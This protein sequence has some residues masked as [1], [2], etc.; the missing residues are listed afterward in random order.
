MA[1]LGTRFEHYAKRVEDLNMY[2]SHG[3]ESVHKGVIDDKV[4]A[5]WA[6]AAAAT[7]SAFPRLRRI[8]WAEWGHNPSAHRTILRDLCRCPTVV[9]LVVDMGWHPVNHFAAP[10]TGLD[11]RHIEDFKLVYTLPA[12]FTNITEIADTLNIVGSWLM[13]THSVKSLSLCAP[14][15]PVDLVCMPCAG[16]LRELDVACCPDF[17]PP[18]DLLPVSFPQ[19][20][21][22][23]L[24]GS[25]SPLFVRLAHILLA[26][27]TGLTTLRM[28]FPG[29]Y[30]RLPG[31][32]DAH[33]LL[34]GIHAHAGLR[35]LT[36]RLGLDLEPAAFWACMP[37]L[38]EL[39]YL[40]VPRSK[41][42]AAAVP[43]MRALYPRAAQFEFVMAAGRKTLSLAQLLRALEP[44]HI[45]Q[46]WSYPLPQRGSRIE[47]GWE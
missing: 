27:G 24:T 42:D 18:A 41:M 19:L 7:P 33:T 45:P 37:A 3:A 25:P 10:L 17:V 9:A 46:A 40:C 26:S 23:T 43:A 16:A 39:R 1:N 32:A 22:L 29:G 35:A 34:G 21:C 6:A 44:A 8:A 13:H 5:V 20:R 2:T 30:D 47:D 4:L 14:F 11:I 36:L 28:A 12:T 15:R 38:P 31:P